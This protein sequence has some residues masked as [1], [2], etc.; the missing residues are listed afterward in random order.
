MTA[1]PRLIQVSQNPPV[2]VALAP[3][4][5]ALALKEA[6]RADAAH[7][8]TLPRWRTAEFLAGRSL[9]RNL[10]RRTT[11]RAGAPIEPDPRGRPV[12]AGVPGIGVS[13][14]HDE[15]FVAAC[16]GRD[17]AVGVDVQTPPQQVEDRLLRR[18]LHTQADRLADAPPAH[19]ARELA[20]VWTV[21]EAVVKAR[22]LGLAALPWTIDVPL[23]MGRGQWEQYR[24][25]SLRRHSQIPLSCAFTPIAG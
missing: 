21:Q 16:V 10:L 8:G 14:S 18:V 22:G 2:W 17:A 5:A 1:P 25:V 24:W 6:S 4:P 3:I 19:R 20:W 15:R 13:I 11:G 12:L 7:A 9:L 23:G